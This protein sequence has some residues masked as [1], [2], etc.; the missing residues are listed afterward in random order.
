MQAPEI[1]ELTLGVTDPIDFTKLSLLWD[2]LVEVANAKEGRATVCCEVSKE[3]LAV[4]EPLMFESLF[5]TN[6]V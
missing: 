3:G 5:L 1:A 4:C 6:G 2:D